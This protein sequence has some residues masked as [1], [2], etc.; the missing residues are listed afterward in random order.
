[1]LI[2]QGLGEYGAM[3]GLVSAF[4]G[5]LTLAESQVRQTEPTTWLFIAAGLVAIW[6]LLIRS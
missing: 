5:F 2:A 1:M 4:D 6:Y 3:S